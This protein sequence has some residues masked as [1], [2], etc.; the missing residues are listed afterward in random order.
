MYTD[1]ESN[2]AASDRVIRAWSHITALLKEAKGL[3]QHAFEPITDE[4]EL[5]YAS[6]NITPISQKTR[7]TTA[8]I[9]SAIMPNKRFTSGTTRD[10]IYI[11]T[12]KASFDSK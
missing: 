5:K 2:N 6:S 1:D 9:R 11:W 12:S 3:E 8:S 10:Y 4:M 7:S